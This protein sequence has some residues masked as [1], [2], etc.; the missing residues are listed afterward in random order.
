MK[1][2][3]PLFIAILV[4]VP[5]AYGEDPPLFD[6]RDY[7]YYEKPNAELFRIVADAIKTEQTRIYPNQK[8]TIQEDFSRGTIQGDWCPT[9][10]GEV[11]ELIQAYVMGDL[12]QIDV[13]HKSKWPFSTPHKGLHSK[14]SE[15]RIQKE[16][17]AKIESSPNKR[18]QGIASPIGLS[19]H[20]P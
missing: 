18:L 4:V 14:L 15:L 6:L 12:Y 10:K 20:E 8:C 7:V 3:I 13:W 11:L 2:V 9:H 19:T 16:I 17:K 1:C 5:A